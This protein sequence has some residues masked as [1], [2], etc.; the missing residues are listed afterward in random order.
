MSRIVLVHGA[1]GNAKGWGSAFIEG[2]KAKG[3]SVETFDLPAQG[4]DPTPKEAV[5]MQAYAD[6]TVAQLRSSDEP[7]VL[8]GHSMGGVVVTQAADDFVAA[9]GKLNQVIYVTAFLPRNG[10]SLLDLAGTP[11]GAGDAVQANLVVSGEP[12]IGTFPAAAAPEALFNTTSAEA[13]AT[14]PADGIESQPIIPF[15]NP[16]NI[17]DDRDITR[18]YI[19]AL[20]DRAIPLPLQ[21]KMAHDTKVVETA[22]IDCDHM[23]FFSATDELVDVIDRFARS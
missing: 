9:G 3:H 5:T 21:R 1:M 23:A 4:E 8:I 15:T 11:E 14:V 16:V 6:K 12:P 20:Q 22:E 19:F 17:T 13:F 2:L 18:R 7:A 10:Q